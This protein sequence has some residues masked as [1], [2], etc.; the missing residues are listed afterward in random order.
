M[1]RFVLEILVDIDKYQTDISLKAIL[2]IYAYFVIIKYNRN[3]RTKSNK[4]RASYAKYI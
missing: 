4:V 2:R 1:C 3:V